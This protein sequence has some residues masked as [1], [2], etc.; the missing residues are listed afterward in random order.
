MRYL[1]LFV[2]LQGR[3]CLI[4]GGGEVALRKARLLASAGAELHV[5]APDV[6][7]PLREL[8]SSVTQRPFADEDVHA[9]LAL[10]VAATPSEP[11]NAR[12]AARCADLHVPVNVVDS[13]ALSSV[14]FPSIVDRDPVIV[15][16]GT[17]GSSPV[18][19]RMLRAR[20]EALLPARLGDL[21]SFAGRMRERVAARLHGD[22]RRRFWEQVLTGPIATQ[23]QEG[24]TEGAV[25]AVQALLDA[26]ASGD[27][28]SLVQQGE[29]VLVGAGPGDPDLLTLKALQALQQA[30][31]VLHDALV[32]PA[33]L[34]R[35]RRDAER[36]LVGGRRGESGNVARAV[37]QMLDLAR[38][39]KRVV[40]LKGGDPMVFAR[41]GEEMAGLLAAGVRLRVVPGVTA[42]MGAAAY[43]GV[44][45]THR[46]LAHS[47][48]MV[49]ARR[50]GGALDVDWP[51]LT[52]PHQT[53]AIYMG[54]SVLAE[55]CAG[56][57]AHGASAALPAMLIENATLPSQRVVVATLSTLPVRVVDAMPSGP[58]LL[59]I[60]EV[61]ALRARD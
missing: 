2:Q 25:T 6:V 4:V 28:Q 30:D 26:A 40:R 29:V 36:H 15:A 42:A 55:L 27:A 11:V 9:A 52:R 23:V 46:D 8:A 58:A 61:V 44:P 14:V 51:A 18:L 60:G 16:F 53:V 39:G 24:D 7:Q 19:A 41:S 34:D 33:V 37:A 10:V 32:P 13:A 1:P 20:L 21:A 5:V 50:R 17:G 56:L 45:L 47:L 22:G 38:A 57:I 49:T 3:P 12:V 35:A 31:V 54:G 59:L 48:V 43:A